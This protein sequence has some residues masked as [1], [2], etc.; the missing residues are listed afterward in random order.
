MGTETS[1]LS[2]MSDLIYILG[3]RLWEFLKSQDWNK[4][5]LLGSAESGSPRVRNLPQ[6]SASRPWIH[7]PHSQ[8]HSPWSPGQV[9]HLSAGVSWYW[10]GTSTN[11]TPSLCPVLTPS[12]VHPWHSSIVLLGLQIWGFHG[13]VTLETSG[14]V[15]QGGTGVAQ[16]VV[17]F[18]GVCATIVM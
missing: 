16:A 3:R 17:F 15:G 8:S 6:L 14:W 2:L 9:P 18:E 7:V 1:I 5:F 11:N 4:P 13:P 10:S 12:L